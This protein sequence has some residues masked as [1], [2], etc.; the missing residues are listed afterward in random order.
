MD[1]ELAQHYRQPGGVEQFGIEAI[2]EDR[3]TVKW[4]DLFAIILNFLVNP[5]TILVGALAVAAGL[6]FWAAV[7]SLVLGISIAFGAYVVMA[8]VGV[9]YGLPGQVATRFAFGIRGAKVA[10]SILR[11]I[12]SVYW[13]AFQTIAGALGI[14]AVLHQITGRD[15]N[16]AVVSV[17][18][19]FAQALIATVGYNSLKYLSRV[20]FFSK[21]A[22][23]AI[24]LWVLISQQGHSPL[25]VFGYQG[26]LGWN[27]VV[28][29]VWVNAAAAA[30]LSMITDAADFCRYS[31]SRADM[32]VG[33]F[34]AAVLG[35]GIS[36]FLGGYAIASVAGKNTNPFDVMAAGASL[37]VL[38]ALLIYVVFDN[39]TINVLNLYTGGL[40]LCNIFTKVGRFWTT[41]VV[42]ALG[43]ALSLF[44]SLING[45]SSQV[46]IIGD[47]FAPIAGILI[48]DYVF[49]RH[50]KLDVP[51]LFQRNGR[52]WYWRGF[53]WVAIGW[54]ILGFIISVFIPPVMI[55]TLSTMIITGVLYLVTEAILRSRVDVVARAAAD[56]EVRVDLAQL[57][58]ELAAHGAN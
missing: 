24:L 53:N 5:G 6:A 30:W 27:W 21:I 2:P 10:P 33:T 17:L 20:A 57:D 14:V 7:V 55:K 40:A 12:S 19:A 9:D 50:M 34:L 42:S 29:A 11:S 58:R 49:V 32:W 36:V 4:Y 48:A 28:M 51:A 3:R 8:T 13:F 35:Q 15:F 31:R 47:L 46:S 44:P 45:Y 25:Q 39:W 54:T 1:S 52:Y 22:I 37:W 26:K 18:F 23:T 56:V 16:L 38:I 43:I 41:L